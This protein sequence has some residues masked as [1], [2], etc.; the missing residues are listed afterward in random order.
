MPRM[1]VI[2]LG[3]DPINVNTYNV[4]Y[5]A[6]VP[7]ARQPFYANSAAVSAWAQATT[8]DNQNLQSGAVVESAT[9]QT[10]PAGTVIGTIETYLQNEWSKYQAYINNFNPWIHYGSTWDGT[11]WNITSN[12]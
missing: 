12:P 9:V 4:L 7:A 6:D 3:Q 2:I 8:V 10:F 1:R 5:W 11:T